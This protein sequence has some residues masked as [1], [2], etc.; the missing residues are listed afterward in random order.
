MAKAPQVDPRD[1]VPDYDDDAPRRAAKPRWGR[2]AL[3]GLIA[4]AVLGGFAMVV[5]TSYD[6]GTTE[7]GDAVAPV[8]KAQQGP[9]K[10]KPD[11][12]G[13]MRIPDQD[14]QV[15]TRLDPN[16]PKSTVEHLLPPPER[17]VDKPPA[18]KP[19]ADLELSPASRTAPPPAPEPPTVAATPAPPPKLAVE[20]PPPPPVVAPKMAAKRPAPA[21]APPPE[22][23]SPQQVAKA[24]T[25]AA[26]VEPASGGFRVQLVALRSE[27][28]AHDAWS[29]YLKQNA[30]L[31]GKLEPTVARADIKGKGTFYRL[32]VGPLADE[33][34][35]RKLCEQVKKRKIGCLVVKP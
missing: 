14:K 16:A 28:A 3:T 34:A 29:K 23:A 25:E 2:R 13:G 6:R 22:P 17:T 18:P 33:G 5:V 11:E 1:R 26:G 12:P 27:Q 24:V 8:V 19:S 9:I 21:A 10:V 15:F 32:Q 4:L 31:F 20:V 35:A 7:G 30:D